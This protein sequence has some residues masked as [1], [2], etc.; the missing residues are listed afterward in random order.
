V[1]EA[2]ESKPCFS[3]FFTTP[4]P[5]DL[6]GTAAR[7]LRQGLHDAALDGEG[8]CATQT[9][10]Q[11]GGGAN[12][13]SGAMD[14]VDHVDQVHHVDQIH[15][16]GKVPLAGSAESVSRTPRF[17]TESERV[18]TNAQFAPLWEAARFVLR[19]C[20]LDS[21]RVNGWQAYAAV[22][23]YAQAVGNPNDPVVIWYEQQARDSQEEQGR[24][25]SWWS[26]WQQEERHRLGLD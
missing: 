26:S 21:L 23:A 7:G 18:M 10:G 13:T 11:G 8:R 4:W 15:A 24:F 5:R 2:S 25:F 17:T 6:H 20:E 9:S 3:P 12:Q 14:Q 1:R 22:A 16:R 19:E